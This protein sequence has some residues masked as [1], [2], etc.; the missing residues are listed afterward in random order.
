MSRPS[1]SRDP[2]LEQAGA[3]DEQIQ[4][5]HA[6]LVRQKPEPTDTY[7]L[8]PIFLLF[9]FSALVFVS[10]VY[11]ERYSSDFSGLVYDETY[12]PSSASAPKPAPINPVAQGKR[13]FDSICITCHQANGEGVPGVYPPLAGSEWVLGTEHRTIRILL[14]GLQGKVTVRGKEFPGSVAMPSFGPSGTNWSD[15][16]I[17]YVLTYIR[18][19]WGNKDPAVTPDAVAK[20]RAA[21]TDFSKPMS[22]AELLEIK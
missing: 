17:A 20:I 9:I 8:M 13:L 22:E 6:E 1:D 7:P 16:Q 19:E 4:E 14:H 15:A 10:A 12:H 3:S 5:V 18:Q 2:R 11:I 21:T